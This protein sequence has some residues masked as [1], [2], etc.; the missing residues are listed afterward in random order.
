MI[1][2]RAAKRDDIPAVAELW[3]HA[4]PG[5]RTFEERVRMLERT[6]TYGGLQTVT[7]ADDG[8]IAGAYKLM[9]LT[10]YVTGVALPAAG[11]AAVAVS[12]AHRRVG[13]GKRMCAHAL[14]EARERGDVLSTLYPF[15]PAFYASLGWGLFARLHRHRFRT[16]ALPEGERRRSRVRLAEPGDLARIADCYDRVAA[17]SNGP[18]R[19]NDGLWQ[20]RLQGGPAARTGRT[21][22]TGGPAAWRAHRAGLHVFL[23]DDGAG[24]LL[25]RYRAGPPDRLALHIVELIAERDDVY[26]ELLGWV[27]G[28]QDQ[29]PVTLYD[30]RP[31][32]RFE[33]RLAQPRTPGEPNRRRLWF[34]TARVLQGPM[35]RIVDIEGAF[36]ARRWWGAP[37]EMAATTARTA[38]PA[39]SGTPAAAGPSAPSGSGRD[40]CALRLEVDDPELPENRGPW[41]I[42]IVGQEMEMR[43]A[44]G[45]AVDAALSLD[46]SALAGIYAG[47]LSPGEA[48]RL[49]RARVDGDIRLPDRVFAAFEKPWLLDEF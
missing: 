13:L 7:V 27:A 33:H 14:R 36:A 41:E 2:M 16:S 42:E 40:R 15:R 46:A 3:C 1:R 5:H 19:R 35:L 10:Q 23:H 45:G 26:A 22:D 44:A 29:W 8:G 38:A 20:N 6:G 37:P 9:R 34:P 32:E 24:Y 28:Q 17:R 47:E 43:P 12:P 48:V 11:L 30:A 21:R 31:A 39:T 18:L 49:G 4:F 25:A